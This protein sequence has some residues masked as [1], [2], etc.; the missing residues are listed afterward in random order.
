[1]K[2]GEQEFYYNFNWEFTLM[3]VNNGGKFSLTCLREKL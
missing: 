2:Q 3:Y 1:M